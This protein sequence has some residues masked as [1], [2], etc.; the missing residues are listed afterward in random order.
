MTEITPTIKNR[1]A[2][3]GTYPRIGMPL[4]STR[5]AGA[6]ALYVVPSPSGGRPTLPRASITAIW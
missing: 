5:G 6:V 2:G 1:P 4:P 3:S